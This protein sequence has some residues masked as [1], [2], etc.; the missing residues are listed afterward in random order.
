MP[1]AAAAAIAAGVY[2]GANEERAG[3]DTEDAVLEGAR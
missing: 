1:A 3:Q 2:E